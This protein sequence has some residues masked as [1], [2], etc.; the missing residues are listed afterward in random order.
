MSDDVPQVLGL[1]GEMRRMSLISNGIE[2]QLSVAR[3]S[4]PE[5]AAYVASAAD[6][7]QKRERLR[8]VVLQAST[9]PVT[10]VAFFFYTHLNM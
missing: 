5:L 3:M 8:L 9:E 7:L 1:D 6:V 4:K 10:K 2:K